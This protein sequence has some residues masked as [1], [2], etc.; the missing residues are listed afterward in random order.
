[1][2]GFIIQSLDKVIFMEM[3]E[4][5]YTSEGNMKDKK[6]HWQTLPLVYQWTLSV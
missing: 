3:G 4:S 6:S 1:M 5:S 2:K